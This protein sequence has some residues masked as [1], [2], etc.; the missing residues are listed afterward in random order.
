MIVHLLGGLIVIIWYNIFFVINRIKKLL[1]DENMSIGATTSNFKGLISFFGAYR[2]IEFES[3]KNTP[4]EIAIQVE[5]EL[6]FHVLTVERS[7]FD[8][9]VNNLIKHVG[10]FFRV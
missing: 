9:N 2:E 6:I 8:Q 4:K 7:T 1:Q 3:D 10:I 5:V